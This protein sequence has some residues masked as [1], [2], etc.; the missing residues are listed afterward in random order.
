MSVRE[1]DLKFNQLSKYAPT[2][3]VDS[4]AMKSTFVS[5]MSEMVVKEFRIAML[6]HDMDISRLMVH[7]QQIEKDK[8]KEN[9]REVK[10]AKTCDGNFSHARFDGQGHPEFQQRFFDQGSSN[11]PLKFNK[12]RCGR[13]HDGNCLAGTDGCYGCGKNGHKMRDFPVLA[14]KEREGKQATPSGSRSNAPK[15]NRF[16]A[17]QT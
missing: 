6:I 7:A 3:V 13:K 9:S 1:Y 17:L 2:M 15:Q 5:G 12:D 14:A 4:R 10:R 11:A 16:Y 8:L